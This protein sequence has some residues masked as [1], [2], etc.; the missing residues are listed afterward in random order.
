LHVCWSDKC[1]P[2]KTPNDHWNSPSL[3]RSDRSGGPIEA[4]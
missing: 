3:R 1:R 2:P 4:P